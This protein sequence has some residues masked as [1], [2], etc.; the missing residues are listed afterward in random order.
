M[1]VAEMK[2]L[3]YPVR[4]ALKDTIKNEQVHERLAVGEETG[5][6]RETGLA[7]LEHLLR[8]GESYV[9]ERVEGMGVGQRRRP[10]RRLRY[11]IWNDMEVM[12]LT[13]EEVR[14]RNMWKGDK[15][16]ARRTLRS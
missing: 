8:R 14:D 2:L 16:F 4:L 7:S 10:K 6:L 15:R 12:G 11:C 13:E 1:Q 5:I 3:R 9:G